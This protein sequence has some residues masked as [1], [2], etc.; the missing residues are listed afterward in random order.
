MV[1]LH[2]SLLTRL[3]SLLCVTII[4]VF[5]VQMDFCLPIFLQYRIS[6]HLYEI[7][8]QAGIHTIHKFKRSC[9]YFSCVNFLV[10]PR[11]TY[12]RDLL[13][14]SF[15]ANENLIYQTT[16]NFSYYSLSLN[17]I[18]VMLSFCHPFQR[19]PKE[20]RHNQ[21]VALLNAQVFAFADAQ[22][23]AEAVAQMV[24]QVASQAVFRHL[25]RQLLMWQ[26]ILLLRLLLWL[27][28]YWF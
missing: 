14:M 2:N 28:A 3:T 12:L 11:E 23:V 20:R 24:A 25:H 5:G 1:T 13:K 21:V 8:F 26:L 4:C 18:I 7:N 10:K 27:T 22:A 17:P 9:N 15:K 16:C 6:T 19:L